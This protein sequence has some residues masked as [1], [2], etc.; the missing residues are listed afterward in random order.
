MDNNNFTPPAGP[1]PP[2]KTWGI[3]IVVLS[4]LGICG[5]GCILAGGGILGALGGAAAAGGAATADHGAVP[6]AAVAATG[7]LIMALGV[8]TLILSILQLYAGTLIM[9][10]RK[11]GFMIAGGCAGLNLLVSLAS[12]PRGLLGTLVSA[13]VLYYCVMR[14]TNKQGPPVLD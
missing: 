2:D 11:L 6:A 4:C 14:L 10:S 8:V 9:K 12:F 13:V 5:G 1:Y 7:G 3:V